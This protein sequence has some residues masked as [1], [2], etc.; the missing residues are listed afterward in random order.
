MRIL[1]GVAKRSNSDLYFFLVAKLLLVVVETSIDWL[2]KRQSSQTSTAFHPSGFPNVT[3]PKMG[4]SIPI[5]TSHNCR[6]GSMPLAILKL[7]LGPGQLVHMCLP[8]CTT[9]TLMS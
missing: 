6:I 3:S 2:S 1:E 7:F 5:P 8:K 9:I 4:G